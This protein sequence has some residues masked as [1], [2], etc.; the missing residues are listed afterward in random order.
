MARSLP[1]GGGT[2][3]ISFGP[4]SVFTP[5]NA[6]SWGCWFN[7]SAFVDYGTIFGK[8]DGST[9]G[10]YAFF[11]RSSGTIAYYI[12]PQS[13]SQVFVDPGS[14]T[15]STNKWYHILIAAKS[16]CSFDT[17]INGIP[18]GSKTATLA[19][20]SNNTITLYLGRGLTGGADL[21]A[22][23]G[24]ADAAIWSTTLTQT[25]ALALAYGIKRPYQIRPASLIGF[26]PLDGYQHPAFDYS[27]FGR[28]GILTGTN[29][30]AGPPLIS[31]APIFV[32]QAIRTMP[33]PPPPPPPLEIL[34][35]QIWV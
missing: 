23:N 2:D 4:S 28:H 3:R 34:M 14:A 22:T 35:P 19:L 11:T 7:A 24:I 20:A 18:D 16:N 27:G 32:P 6:L 17:W 29:L 10:S 26:W 13:G 21:G 5:T 9:V 15:L 30:V 25:E 1:G 33:A 31:T 12:T 8:Y